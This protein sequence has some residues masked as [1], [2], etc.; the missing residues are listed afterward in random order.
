MRSLVAFLLLSTAAPALA[1]H[2]H[3]DHQPQPAEEPH[4]GHAAPEQPGSSDPHAGHAM[5]AEDP[6]AGHAGPGDSADPH[7]GHTMPAEPAAPPVAPPPAAAFSGPEHAADLVFP[8]EAMARAR[9]QSREE[10]GDIETSKF[11]LDRFEAQLRDGRDGLAWD[12]Q[13]WYGGDIDKF[14]VKSEG[15]AAFGEGLEA[16]EVQALW[17]RA[18]DPWFDVQAGLRYDV[19]P[20]PERAY[21]VAGVQGLAPYWFEIGAAAF[22]SNKG[23]VSAR[24]EAEYD[25]R[26]TPQL[27]FQPALE[28]EFQLQD[29]PELGVGAGLS[30]AEAGARLRYEIVPEFAPYVGVEYQR[31]FGDTAGFRRAAGE[32]AGGWSLLAGIRAWF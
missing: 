2:E 25:L 30:T 27:I 5:P 19:R 17:S 12:A 29:V 32:K 20:G 23:E 16:A 18:V 22:V 7:A 13:A 21:L 8:E 9:E 11:L 4:A 15:E 26:I 10:H 6:H 28:L 1:Q 31:G 24:F 3:H 14:W